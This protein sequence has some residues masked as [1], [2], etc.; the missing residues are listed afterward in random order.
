MPGINPAFFF[1]FT[2]KMP[3][4]KEAVASAFYKGYIDSAKGNEPLKALKKNT[5]EFK[6]LFAG[7]PEK[8]I[9]YAYANGKWTIREILQHIIDAE[10]VFAYRALRFARK[11]QTPLQSFDQN[12]WVAQAK[13][14][15][16]DWKE[17]IKEFGAVRKSSEILFASFDD[18]Q[19]LSAGIASENPINVL[20]LG[21]I[22]AGHATHHLDII[23]D[24][25]L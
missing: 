17:L 14:G 22:I 5:K 25:Y 9:D 16:R 19:L 2:I 4:K 1:T 13:T 11:D 8:K 3:T 18:E 6:K 12:A 10:R 7:I 20:A 21:F 23:K 15:K 24:R